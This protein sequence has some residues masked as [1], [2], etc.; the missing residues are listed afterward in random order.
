MRS[1]LTPLLVTLFLFF[2]MTAGAWAQGS[3]VIEGQVFNGT[4]GEGPLE[5]V[6]VTLRIL[7]GEEEEG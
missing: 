5:G 6:P 7:K 1:W 2:S 4:S 3:G